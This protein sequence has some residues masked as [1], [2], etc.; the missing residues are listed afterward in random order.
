MPGDW[1]V[2]SAQYATVVLHIQRYAGAERP[3]ALFRLNG[4][5]WQSLWMLPLRRLLLVKSSLLQHIPWYNLPEGL[6]EEVLRSP[7]LPA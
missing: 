3:D 2:L 6:H 4:G 1:G 5:P 7:R